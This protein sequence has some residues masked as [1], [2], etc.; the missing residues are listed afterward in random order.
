MD[1]KVEGNT[2]TGN[3]YHETHVEN[4]ENFCPNATKVVNNHIRHVTVQINFR[5]TIRLDGEA[6]SRLF[7]TLQ[8]RY[9]LALGK[10]KNTRFDGEGNPD[11]QICR[12]EGTPAGVADA[13]RFIRESLGDEAV[14]AVRY[15]SKKTGF[16]RGNLT[17][18]QAT[19]IAEYESGL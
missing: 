7:Q 3:S 17:L 19:Q 14:T 5:L 15:I 6:M 12:L 1:L 10:L 18:Q 4:V 9:R 2:G 16:D 8:S 13:L 11:V